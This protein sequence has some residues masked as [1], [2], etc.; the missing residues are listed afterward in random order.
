MAAYAVKLLIDVTHDSTFV[1]SDS[2]IA[3]LEG[4]TLLPAKDVV[5]QV[6]ALVL[7][8]TMS[9]YPSASENLVSLSSKPF[10]WM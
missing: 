7:L 3:K 9:M 8:I 5:I 2:S 1:I 4:Q 10:F 6:S